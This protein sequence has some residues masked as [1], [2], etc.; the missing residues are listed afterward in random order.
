[1]GITQVD[2]REAE[3]F[4]EG[5]EP[6]FQ[7]AEEGS[8][9][10]L[11]NKPDSGHVSGASHGGYGGS[12]LQ[13]CLDILNQARSNAPARLEIDEHPTRRNNQEN[14]R[15]EGMFSQKGVKI[16]KKTREN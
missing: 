14:N 11:G 3:R 2:S 5:I 16:T 10:T 9:K 6:V 1:M 13:E 7:D 12:S 8:P 15:F 4:E